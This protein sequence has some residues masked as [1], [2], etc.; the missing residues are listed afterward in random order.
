MVM[1]MVTKARS[2][3]RAVE[4]IPA[5]EFKATCLALMD[6]VAHDGT[7]ITVT[8]RG[9]PVAVLSPVLTTK[10]SAFG[11]ARGQIEI[12]GDIVAPIDVVWD[13]TQ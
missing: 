2:A 4:S 10:A 3:K 11:F 1:F 8:K 9:K 12:L 7:S 5:G 6:R 13:A